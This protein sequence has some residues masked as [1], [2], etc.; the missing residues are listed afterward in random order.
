MGKLRTLWAEA[1]SATKKVTYIAM[2]IGLV[3]AGIGLIGDAYGWWEGRS[4]LTN[5]LSSFTGLCFAVPFALL[6]LNYLAE[7]HAEAAQRRAA[8]RTATATVAL[9]DHARARLHLM[10]EEL[11]WLQGPDRPSDPVEAHAR[12]QQV[13]LN[14]WRDIMAWRNS[15]IRLRDTVR[16]L[17]QTN[18]ADLY[19]TMDADDFD[20]LLRGAYETADGLTRTSPDSA[21]APTEAVAYWHNTMKFLIGVHVYPVEDLKP[22]G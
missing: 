22:T 14:H 10:C 20:G 5:V 17:L 4:Y 8:W 13:I 18:D 7:P 19:V 9:Y 21:A 11:E 3:L 12:A 2:P 15:W 16:P 1:P 6:I